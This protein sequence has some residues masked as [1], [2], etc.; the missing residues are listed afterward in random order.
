MKKILYLL[1]TLLLASSCQRENKPPPTCTEFNANCEILKEWCLVKPLTLIDTNSIDA[2]G[3]K[4]V[5]GEWYLR[6]YK[7]KVLIPFTDEFQDYG[8]IT[9][10][11]LEIFEDTYPN[12]IRNDCKM[13]RTAKIDTL[14]NFSDHN[15][16]NRTYL[17]AAAILCTKDGEVTISSGNHTNGYKVGWLD[18]K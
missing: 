7:T 3:R 10:Q 18:Y 2:L 1:F 14:S 8:S 17:I 12:I 11:N 5:I 4:L 16:G 13:L 15:T 6:N 9:H